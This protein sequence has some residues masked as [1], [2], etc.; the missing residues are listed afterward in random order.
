[1]KKVLYIFLLFTL[2]FSFAA[3]SQADNLFGIFKKSI[4]GSGDIVTEDREVDDFTRIKLSGSF[5]IYVETGKDLSLTVTFD[6][7]LID[8]ITTEVRGKTLRIDSEGSFS[9]RKGCKIHITVPDLQEVS[10]SGSGDVEVYGL[11]NDFF[12]LSISGSGDADLEGKVEELEVKVS[13]SGDID[14]REL[15]AQDVYAKV[16]GSGDITVTAMQKLD[17]RVYGSGDITYY[18]D[19]DRVKRSISGSGDISRR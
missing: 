9:S 11:D 8:L 16:S 6:D 13:G 4:K 2:I 18:G 19:P 1:M 3:S 17:A 5:D 14:A 7:N 10:L 15:V 12:E